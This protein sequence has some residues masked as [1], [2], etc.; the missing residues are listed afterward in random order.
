MRY[1]L[2]R[3]AYAI[4]VLILVTIIIFVAV[5][6][7]P[8]DPA[9]MKLGPFGTKT[10]E[11]IAQV[12]ESMGLDKP[13]YV[14]YFYWMKD[15]LRGDLGV[16]LRNGQPVINVIMQKVPASLELIGLSLVFALLLSIPLGV[17]SAIK[18]NSWF[19]QATSV[20]SVGLLAIP[21][22]WLGLLL[23]LL[24]SV[25][26]KI[27]PASG[28]VPFTQNPIMNLKLVIMPVIS[29]GS[30]EMAYFLRFIRSDMIEVLNSNY[31][32]T[33]RAKG[34]PGKRIYFR[35]ALKNVLV[36]LIT[37]VGLEFGGLL[38]GT[39]ITEQLF[40]WSGIGWLI[41]QSITKRDYPV[42][43]GVVLII[44]V[45]F[46]VINLIVDLLYAAIDHRIKFD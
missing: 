21:S 4:P 16:S 42:V 8:G 41:F 11:Q 2:K 26:L 25:T 15:V 27:L 22:F 10:P 46:V 31:I 28:Y 3:I 20:I 37:V 35:H 33:A 36:T 19:D 43:Q 6:L 18:R 13:I 38:G 40:G 39:V 14:Q 44:A 32:R 30:F 12:R 1:A 9:L 24:F 29:L 34:L 45:A 5:R 7:A 17:I 23:L